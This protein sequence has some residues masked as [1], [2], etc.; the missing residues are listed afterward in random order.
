MNCS[1]FI[2]LLGEGPLTPEALAHMRA[3]GSCL[4]KAVLA[5]GDNLFRSLGGTELEPAGGIDQFAAEV[6]H[7]IHVR[8]AESKI[9]RR[10]PMPAAVRWSIAATLA[11]GVA[12]ASLLYRPAVTP[13]TAPASQQAAVNDL[14]DPSMTVP[15]VEEYANGGAT[16]VEMASDSDLKLVMIFD[17]SLPA[18]L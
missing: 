11:V 6:M 2:G 8:E 12:A 9:A 3:C 18:D 4:E 14:F 7:Q 17:E 16:I 13:M 5:D 15:V 10:R 1:R